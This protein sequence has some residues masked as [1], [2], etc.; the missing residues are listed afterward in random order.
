MD[1]WGQLLDN[2]EGKINQQTFNTWLKPTQQISHEQGQLNVWVPSPVFS[3]WITKNY[4]DQIRSALSE[5]D[6][7]EAEVTFVSPQDETA[8]PAPVPVMESTPER[9]T[10]LPT[11]NPRFSF[12]SFVVSSCNQFAHA[13]ARAV[14]EKPAHAY[15]PLYLYGGVGLGKTHLMHSIGNAVQSLFPN[16]RM[17]YLSTEGFM[18]ELINAIRFEKTLDFKRKYRNVDLL[19][20]DDIQFLAGKE[21]TQEE[22][23]HTFNA[24]YDA[25]KQIVLTSDCTPREIPTLEERLRSR[26][27]CGLIA[28]LQPPDLE[29]K[30]A[31]LRKKAEAERVDL[32]QDVALY[33]A[34]KIRSNIREMEG[35]L[36]RLIAYSSLT[37]RA[38]DLELAKETLKGIFK[39]QSRAI[40]AESI[41]RFVANYYQI[42]PSDLKLKNNSS[43][44]TFPR[45]ISMYLCK[46]LTDL[47]LPEI[48]KRFGGKHHSTVI[49]SVRKIADMRKKKQDFDKLIHSFTESIRDT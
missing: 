37:R 32:P 5:L 38:I 34:S 31:I 4:Q 45:Q 27:E 35:A 6:A 40:T 17:M 48:G 11:V 2:L 47:S 30:I 44:V 20:I 7:P 25:Q 8:P 33:I 9:P 19:L 29:T 18:N 43:S 23:F 39:D 26:F 46:Q 15:N 12:D 22:F 3:E 24:L 14:A 42:K 1:L 13:A 28:D 49:H 36:I 41:Q 10:S 21:R 16:M